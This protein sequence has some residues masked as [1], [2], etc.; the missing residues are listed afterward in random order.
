MK[1]IKIILLLILSSVIMHHCKNKKDDLPGLPNGIFLT[2][3]SNT[4]QVDA[5]TIN[6]GTSPVYIKI[7]VYKPASATVTATIIQDNPLV[8]TYNTVHH[9]NYKEIPQANITLPAAVSIHTGE[10]SSD[11]IM[12]SINSAGLN[13]T[14]TY[15]LPITISSVSGGGITLNPTEATKY[16]SI[17]FAPPPNIAVG[18]AITASSEGWGGSPSRANDGNTDGNYG[19]NS[20]YHSADNDNEPYIEIDLGFVSPFISQVI[21]Y[22]RTDCCPDRLQNFHLFVSDTPLPRTIQEVQQVTGIFDFYEPTQPSSPYVVQVRKPGR[23]VRV[24]SVGIATL[25]LAEMEIMAIE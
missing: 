24:Q 16:I 17:T 11:S 2:P 5:R 21:L 4:S 9:S 23:Y 19:N 6:N 1:T 3:V 10:S 12:I 25:N 7:A 13:I 14:E 8:A 18:K 22:K 15:L 20:V